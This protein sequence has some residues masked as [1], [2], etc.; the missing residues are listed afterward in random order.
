[1]E[2][3]KERLARIEEKI[4]GLKDDMEEIKSVFGKV[5]A[6]EKDLNYSK[7]VFGT[8]SFLFTAGM[9]YLGLK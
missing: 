6:I 4:N 8:L 7:G 9:S 1:M 5:D 3:D 2:T